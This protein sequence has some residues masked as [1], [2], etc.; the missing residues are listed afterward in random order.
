MTTM[1]EVQSLI[2]GIGFKVSLDPYSANPLA[3]DYRAVNPETY[4]VAVKMAGPPPKLFAAGTQDLPTF[5]ASGIDPALLRGIPYT[6]RHAVA[7]MSSLAAVHDVFEESA[8]DPYFT[9]DHRGLNEAIV[10]VRDWAA[11]RRDI[12]EEPS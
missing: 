7:A 3:D 11:G 9:I 12:T 8:S 2:S 4:A 10:R 5:C 1:I 6:A